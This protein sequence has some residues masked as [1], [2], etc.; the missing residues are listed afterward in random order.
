MLIYLKPTGKSAKKKTPNP[1]FDL[2]KPPMEMACFEPRPAGAGVGSQFGE[3]TK[4]RALT[5][6]PFGPRIRPQIA[7]D[8]K[9]GQSQRRFGLEPVQKAADFDSPCAPPQP[10]P[11]DPCLIEVRRARFKRS[12][13]SLSQVENSSQ[14]ETLKKAAINSPMRLLQL[15]RTKFLE[16]FG[17]WPS[18]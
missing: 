10:H 16:P 7:P 6:Y 17:I 2:Q 9:N 11:I 12:R 15:R 5:A 14:K 3:K 4:P 18:N 8:R 1:R 13:R